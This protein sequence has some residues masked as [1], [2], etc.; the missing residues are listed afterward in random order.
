[1]E[2]IARGIKLIYPFA[3]KKCNRGD[4]I[5]RTSHWSKLEEVVEE[6]RRLMLRSVQ[7]AVSKGKLSRRKPARAV[8][9]KQ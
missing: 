4:C 5:K 6:I 8:G 9:K 1:M 3:G 7:E 2:K